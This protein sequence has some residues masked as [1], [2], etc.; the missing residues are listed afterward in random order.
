M[1][2]FSGWVGWRGVVMVLGTLSLSACG[3]QLRGTVPMSAELQPLYVADAKPSFV[4]EAVRQVARQSAI[5]LAAGPQGAKST[6]R[7]HHERQKN[8][9]SAV[10]Q[11]G[12]V[13]E[14]ELRYQVSYSIEIPARQVNLAHQELR[15]TRN[16][17]NPEIDMLG[18]EEE[19]QALYQDM[20]R[21]AAGQ[22]L[23]RFEHLGR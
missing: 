16:L 4:A 21:D 3:F 11:S 5:T 20:A 2:H 1:K 8:Q 9:V 14:Y 13:V 19:A 23:R 18:K 7:I 6:V 15:L 12:K 10:N 17:V 22:I